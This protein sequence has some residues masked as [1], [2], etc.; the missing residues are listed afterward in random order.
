MSAVISCQFQ[1]NKRATRYRFPKTD[2][3]AVARYVLAQ[4]VRTVIRWSASPK[5][6]I[7]RSRTWRQQWRTVRWAE[8]G[9]GAGLSHST[10]PS[11]RLFLARRTSHLSPPPSPPWRAAAV[12][13]DPATTT[14]RTMT[15]DSGRS[16]TVHSDRC[17][18][19]YNADEQ[20]SKTATTSVRLI[21]K[22]LSDRYC[23]CRY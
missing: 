7:S 19:H 20:G 9:S 21:I 17:I 16:I 13:V 3:F 10:R 8:V 23:A 2:A 6:R 11:H 15:P 22:G 14:R 1:T 18:N 5:S 4:T 12:S